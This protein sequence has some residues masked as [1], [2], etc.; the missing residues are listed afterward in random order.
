MPA[1]QTPL[2]NLHKEKDVTRWETLKSNMHWNLLK[3]LNNA[4]VDSLAIGKVPKIQ[5]Y[6]LC[7]PLEG[8][9]IKFQYDLTSTI[10][11]K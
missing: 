5:L 2:S 8:D 6:I 11:D 10:T 7:T 1:C 3:A 4:V 9:K